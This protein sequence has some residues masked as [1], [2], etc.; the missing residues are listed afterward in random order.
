M[1]ITALKDEAGEIK[2]A[3][4]S[5]LSTGYSGLACSPIPVWE[6]VNALKLIVRNSHFHQRI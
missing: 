4:L 1:I 5:G 6:G 3:T 2:E